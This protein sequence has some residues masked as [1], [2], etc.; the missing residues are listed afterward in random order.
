MAPR[1]GLGFSGYLQPSSVPPDPTG[2]DWRGE[3]GPTG[4]PGPQGPQ[5]A[6]GGITG[7]QMTGPLTF[8]TNT[9]LGMDNAALGGVPNMYMYSNGGAFVFYADG[10]NEWTTT[11]FR[12]INFKV[13]GN[14]G[15]DEYW[16]ATGGPNGNGCTLKAYSVSGGWHCI[17]SIL[18][19]NEGELMLGNDTGTILNIQGPTGELSRNS[20]R[21]KGA[22]SGDPATI[23]VV[24]GDT[25]G[26]MMLTA[27]AAGN[28][29]IGNENYIGTVPGATLAVGGLSADQV[30]GFRMAGTP[31]G[32]APLLAAVGNDT[33]IGI[34]V[35][36]KGTG[37]FRTSNDTGVRGAYA[38]DMQ[39]LRSLGTQIASGG[40]A[41][42]SG[43]SSNTA[44]GGYTTVGGGYGNNADGNHSVIPGGQR[45]W[46]RGQHGW[47]GWAAGIVQGIQEGDAQGSWRILMG[48]TSAS[49]PV[50][51]TSDRAAINA[52]SPN[53]NSILLAND[54]AIAMTMMM[55][56]CD[57]TATGTVVN[58]YFVDILIGKRPSGG[59]Y[60][61]VGTPR[62]LGTSG[63]TVSITIGADQLLDVT[64]TPATA[65]SWHFVAKF[66]CVEML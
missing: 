44:S 10:W 9:R 5:G 46:A 52:V 21:I 19:S 2:E 4:P 64:V 16:G 33:D 17:G 39:R 34:V 8:T 58:M 15:A 47:L 3:P 59:N 56:G 11:A 24:S 60:I 30:N 6:T 18:A 12:G 22:G 63:P 31:T 54:R 53:I 38:T 61:Q 26:H 23:S 66:S 49:T 32:S 65:N 28:V 25:D 62:T 41:V 14:G 57:R 35:A 40:E 37:A 7:G 55:V 42:V 45:A 27:K 48:A 29:Y 36:P 50:R 1:D 43:G 51:L 20:L 13:F